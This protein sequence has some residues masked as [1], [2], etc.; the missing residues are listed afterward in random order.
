MKKINTFSAN[1]LKVLDRNIDEFIDKY[2]YNLSLYKK[3]PRSDLGQKFHS[4]ICSY[5]KGI[6]TDKIA[7]D[8]NEKERIIWNN[9]KS[10]L[11]NQR[12]NFIK[13]EYS[14]LIKEQLN[15]KFYY[16]T[17]RFD[18]VYKDGAGYIIYDWKTLNFP[19]EPENDLQTI[20]YL[21]ALSKIY[22]T[23]NI[24]MRY[25]SIERLDFID[26]KFKN[27]NDYKKRIDEIVKKML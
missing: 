10:V 16:L 6:N 17:G 1:S 3:D 5:I 20:V 2:I 9:L 8:L 26:I 18:A 14:F 27:E 22:N 23:K 25:L 21:Y 24:T 19:K 11:S 15:D 4:L 12:E 7:L 13:T